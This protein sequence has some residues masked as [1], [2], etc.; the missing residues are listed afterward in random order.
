MAV[1]LGSCSPSTIGSPDFNPT[2]MRLITM[3]LAMRLLVLIH[4]FFVLEF[5]KN[6]V[7]FTPPPPPESWTPEIGS[8]DFKP[9]YIRLI[10]MKLAIYLL[11]VLPLGCL[12]EFF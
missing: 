2:Y 8:P 7:K 5:S 3:K 10:T 4:R 9:T 1:G 11:R 6:F 12:L